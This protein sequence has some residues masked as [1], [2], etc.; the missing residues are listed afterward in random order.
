[1][2]RAV[3]LLGTYWERDALRTMTRSVGR[4]RF[5]NTDYNNDRR[6]AGRFVLRR[7]PAYQAACSA[8]RK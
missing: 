3:G 6:D 5:L 7:W 2:D 8:A 4:L 1:M